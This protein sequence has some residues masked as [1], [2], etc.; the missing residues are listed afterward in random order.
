MRNGLLQHRSQAIVDAGSV[1]LKTLAH[2]DSVQSCKQDSP[3]IAG[4]K[5]QF[6]NVLTQEMTPVVRGDIHHDFG[7]SESPFR[8]LFNEKASAR[9]FG[10]SN[11]PFQHRVN[12][13][14]P[15]QKHLRSPAKFIAKEPCPADDYYQSGSQSNPQHTSRSDLTK[16][17]AIH[18]EIMQKSQLQSYSKGKKDLTARL[19]RQTQSQCSFKE[20]AGQNMRQTSVEKLLAGEENLRSFGYIFRERNNIGD[21]TH[22]KA[23]KTNPP[24]PEAP[25]ALHSPVRMMNELQRH[26]TPGSLRNSYGGRHM[27]HMIKEIRNQPNF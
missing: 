23:Y 12:N 25:N 3:R 27:Q 1:D 11:G 4:K 10:Q 14:S 7:T 8:K 5:D 15:L 24:Q 13:Y 2:S 22:F 9:G 16:L 17:S 20:Q 26:G 18:R 21:S 19:S 6:Y